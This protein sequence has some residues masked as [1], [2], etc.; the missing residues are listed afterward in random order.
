M[1]EAELTAGAEISRREIL[2]AQRQI[3]DTVLRLAEQGLIA[4]SAVDDPVE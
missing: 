2:A 4:L 3:A 1:V